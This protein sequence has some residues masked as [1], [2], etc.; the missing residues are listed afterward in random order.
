MRDDNTVSTFRVR[1]FWFKVLLVL[2][3]LLLTVCGLGSYGA[4]YY[5]GKYDAVLQ[6]NDQL[7]AELS[8]TR[9]RLQD[10]T[11][12]SILPNGAPGQESGT[13]ASDNIRPVTPGTEAGTATSSIE[14][15]NT[16][17]TA[18]G[19]G[20]PGAV[21]D[22]QDLQN[23]LGQDGQVTS[24]GTPLAVANPEEMEAHAIR[25]SN[26][27]I[28]YEA[29]NRAQ[30][31]FDIANQPQK[32]SLSGACAI[33]AVTRQGELVELETVVRNSL[34]FRIR[35]F[36]KMSAALKMP[37]GLARGDIVSL[38]FVVKVTGLPDYVKT[39]PVT[40]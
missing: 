2:F 16:G 9:V 18:G 34:S 1:T 13:Y 19:Q 37:E 10:R 29:G 21:P 12:L 6:K 28:T 20:T 32:E 36:R 31:I 17:R 40:N 26:V 5:K 4:V 22:P 14:T 33:F 27:S 24:A 11:N 25:V 23:L 35:M 8:E 30:V 15:L 39:F 38:R 3:L 7:Q